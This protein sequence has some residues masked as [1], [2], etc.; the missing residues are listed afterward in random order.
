MC[1]T[2]ICS[3]SCPR[4]SAIQIKLALGEPHTISFG[5]TCRKLLLVGFSLAKAGFNLVLTTRIRRRPFLWK[6]GELLTSC[7]KELKSVLCSWSLINRL[8]SQGKQ[9][10]NPR[11][12]SLFYTL[13]LRKRMRRCLKRQTLEYPVEIQ[14]KEKQQKPMLIDLLWCEVRILLSLTVD[15][16]L[17]LKLL[18]L[19]S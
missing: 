17:K 3:P 12:Y 18:T 7:L 14:P 11:C 19:F 15:A 10:S 4:N 9:C 2:I 1:K 6:M 5:H 8:A 16:I 13:W